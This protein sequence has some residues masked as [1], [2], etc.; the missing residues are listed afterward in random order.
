MDPYGK[1][2]P[3]LDVVWQTKSYQRT[4]VVQC[5]WLKSLNNKR[6]TDSRYESKRVE[7]IILMDVEIGV[8]EGLRAQLAHLEDDIQA[9][10]DEY[11]LG[12][13]Y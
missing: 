1:V 10:Q 9:Q 4:R 12:R 11:E 3:H 7:L 5:D 13:V 2:P 6:N 8:G